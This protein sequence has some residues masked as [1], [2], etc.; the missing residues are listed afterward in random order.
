MK[1]EIVDTI[2]RLIFD[3]E[4]D[5]DNDTEKQQLMRINVVARLKKILLDIKR[6][7]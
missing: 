4:M 2:D 3:I 7:L 6:Y 1:D 5:G